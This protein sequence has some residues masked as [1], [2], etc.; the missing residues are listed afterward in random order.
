MERNDVVRVRPVNLEGFSHLYTIDEYG[1]IFS[2]RKNRYLHI[3][4]NNLGYCFVT[5]TPDNGISDVRRRSVHRIVACTFIGSPPTPK[6]EINHKDHNRSNNHWS[7]LEWLTH[8][9]NIQKSYSEGGMDSS[10]CGQQAGFKWSQEVKDKMRDAKL[11]PV[12]ATFKGVDYKFDSIEDLC[13]YGGFDFMMYRKKYNRIMRDGG[14]YRGWKFVV[15]DRESN[16]MANMVPSVC[17]HLLDERLGIK[18]RYSV[19]SLEVDSMDRP[20]FR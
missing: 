12:V 9:E 4:C 7:N 11:K 10:R 18:S 1:N 16:P 13:L 3:I 17:G 6:H 20:A 5:L 15:A 2:V 19:E 14:E 8:S